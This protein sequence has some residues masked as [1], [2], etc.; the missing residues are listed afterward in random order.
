MCTPRRPWEDPR[1]EFTT[2]S[3]RCECWWLAGTL[4]FFLLFG[5]LGRFSRAVLGVA[6]CTWRTAVAVADGADSER[7]PR[8]S[9]L[10][11]LDMRRRPHLFD[12][13]VL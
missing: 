2:L 4:F 9:E 11:R 7:R 3:L 6:G 5:S 8:F 1:G 12:M 10:A 13:V